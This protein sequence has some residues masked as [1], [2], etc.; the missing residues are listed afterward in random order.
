MATTKTINT[1]IQLRYDT[2][3]NWQSKATA[4]KGALL[5]LN[6]GE[7]ALCYVPA[8]VDT[9]TQKVLTAPT[10]LFKVGD[11][12][13][14]FEN[15]P[16]GSALAADV[17]GW[18][19]EKKK[20]SYTAQEISGLSDYISSEIQDTDT[21]YQIIKGADDYTYTLQSKPLGGSS[22]TDVSTINIP[23]DTL[24]EGTTNG[25]VVFNGD[26]VHVH[27][28]GSAAYADTGA[29]DA[30]GAAAG[31]K[32]ELTGTTTDTWA[33]N[34]TLNAVHNEA[35]AAQETA[36]KAVVANADITAGTHTKI[37]YDAKGLVTKGENLTAADIPNLDAG[38]ITSGTFA[39][40]RI[41][42]IT[43]AKVTD[44]GNAAYKNVA[45]SIVVGS[46]DEGLVTA[47]QVATF[48]KGQV[49]GISGAMHFV[50][51]STT[52]PKDPET[53]ATVA[54]HTKWAAGDVVLF[55]SKEFVL[56]AGT[57]IADNWI[58]LGD[59][60][61]YAVKGEIKNSD[62]ANDAA[63]GQSKIS[64]LVDALAGKAT[65]ADITTEIKKLDAA[66]KGGA[67]KYIQSISQTDGKIAAVEATMPTALKNP[68]ALTI[69]DSGKTYDGGTPITIRA[70][71]LGAVTDVSGKLDKFD[72]TVL[73]NEGTYAYVARRNAT[74]VITQ[75]KQQ[76]AISSEPAP[77]QIPTYDAASRLKT[78]APY[79]ENDAANMKY[80]NNTI[81]T[82]LGEHAGI[83]KVG[84]VTSVATGTGLKLADASMASTTP[85]IV[86]DDAVIFI[87]NGGSA[88]TVIE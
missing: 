1:R 31:V 23:K 67:G 42:D 58:E 71:D 80:V 2:L 74:G 82:K 18:A 81:D 27:G 46:V 55:D 28:L 68:N 36:N 54:G 76:I 78:A 69:G 32:T 57:N 64:G 72:G 24:V 56:K 4:G 6:K 70:D 35:A 48:V 8:V 12:T 26:I 50:G 77:G 21:Q 87:L 41:P 47:A 51:V 39:V 15:L 53:G 20:P 49:A 33:T 45:S 44:K 60:T 5:V 10:V 38:K 59:E 88:T 62:I 52:N 25:A 19:K 34:K 3:E 29:F 73:T 75:T 7:V 16:W 63:I 37:T 14:T 43:L 30:S 79:A 85:T 61:R 17:Y 83:D 86:I 13:T 11:G 9:E 22:W 66:E 65:P 84:T 40:A